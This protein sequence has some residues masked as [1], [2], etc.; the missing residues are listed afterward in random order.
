MTGV[1]TCALPICFPVTIGGGRTIGHVWDGETKDA[2]GDDVKLTLAA[3]EEAVE[4]TAGSWYQSG[5][6]VY[7]HTLDGRAPDTDLHFYLSTSTIL[8]LVDNKTIYLENIHSRGGSAAGNFGNASAAGTNTKAFIKNSS[9]KYGGIGDL[10][11]DYSCKEF[12][13]QNCLVAQ[14]K[15]DLINHQKVN[16]VD[17]FAIEVDVISRNGGSDTTNQA[18]TQHDGGTVVRING[19]YKNSV[20]QNIADVGT[21][22]SWLLGCLAKSSVNGTGFYSARL[23]WL[24]SCRSEG[25]TYP[26]EVPSGATSYIRNFTKDSWNNLI[27][28][29]LLE[30]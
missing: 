22:K 28:G 30:Y 19:V 27:G 26:I 12:I 18:S 23:M 2:N 14:S 5:T 21:G 13:M 9:F 17:P 7:V 24:D 1:Q 11:R 3:S 25:N 16:G 8:Y 10:I 15:A 4:S 6:T 29:T 20:G